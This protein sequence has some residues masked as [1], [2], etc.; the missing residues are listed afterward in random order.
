MAKEGLGGSARHSR[1]AKNQIPTELIGE[2]A[3]KNGSRFEAELIS[4]AAISRISNASLRSCQSLNG[5]RPALQRSRIC[6]TIQ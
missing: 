3:N 4:S 6:R 1:P 5:P 2:I